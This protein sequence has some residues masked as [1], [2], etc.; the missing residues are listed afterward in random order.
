VASE[1]GLEGV[2]APTV[3]APACHDTGSAVA[4]VPATTPNFAWIS[5]GTWSVVGAEVPEPIINERSLHYNFTNEG[6]VG[7][8]FRFSRNVMGLW[9]VQECRRTWARQGQDHT[10]DEL[11]EMAAQAEPFLAVIDPDDGEFFKPGNMPARIREFCG[12][13]GQP[14]PESKGAILRCALEGIALKY[15]WVLDRSE[16]ILGHAL[17]PLYIVGGGTQN[18]LLSQF[19]AD[20]TNRQVIAGPIEATATGNILM[21]ML[22]L[23]LIGTV[24]AGRQIVRNSFSLS[25]Y[26]PGSRVGWDEA[27]ARLLELLPQL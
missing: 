26:E 21:Q 22:A 17:E 11:A 19:T 7:D 5:S 9:L 16:E 24:Q 1:I 2:T 14:I 8:M 6:G 15:R 25:T 3:I 20:A 12:A 23:G 10:Y 27:H 4:A 18:Q 13:T